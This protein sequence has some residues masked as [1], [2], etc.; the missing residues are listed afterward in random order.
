MLDTIINYYYYYYRREALLIIYTQGRFFLLFIP[1]ERSLI[2]HIH[3][4]ENSYFFAY[5]GRGGVLLRLHTGEKPYDYTY[6]QA[7]SL[8]TMHL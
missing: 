6:T 4:G 7:R 3:T 5:Y 2:N 8:T 1:R